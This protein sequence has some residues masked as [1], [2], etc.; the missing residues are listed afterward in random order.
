MAEKRIKQSNV[1]NEM[2]RKDNGR[3]KPFSFSYV[4]LNDSREGNGNPGSIVH[5]P[6]AYFSSIH[7]KGSTVNIRLQ[8][9]RFPK[10]FIKC[11]IIKINSK[12]V[13]A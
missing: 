5:Y 13:F 3:Y 8:G 1:W 10:K 12:K 6:V 2:Q 7:S 11:M 4:R 9:E